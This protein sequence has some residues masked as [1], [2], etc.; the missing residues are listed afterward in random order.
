MGGPGLR[1]AAAV[2]AGLFGGVVALA[3]PAAAATV[4]NNSTLASGDTIDCSFPGTYTMTIPSGVTT[5]TATVTGAGGGGSSILGAA[6]GRGRSVVLTGVTLPPGTLKLRVV[7]GAGGNEQDSNNVA[8]A[9]ASGGG[10]SGL[11]ALGI[12][13]VLVAKLAVAGGGGGAAFGSIGML[14][15]TRKRI[16]APG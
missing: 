11:Y 2:A 9:G 10:G 5:M 8:N 1:V 13:N 4:C 14:A 3:A 7:V 6:G 15:L 16:Q 12:A